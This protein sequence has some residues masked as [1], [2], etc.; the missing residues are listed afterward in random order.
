M[1]KLISKTIGRKY[2]IPTEDTTIDFNK[3]LGLQ[4]EEHV[5]DYY[6]EGT[7]LIVE[8]IEEVKEKNEI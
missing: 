3:I 6:M 5:E 7:F 4:E 8:T 2:K 1:A